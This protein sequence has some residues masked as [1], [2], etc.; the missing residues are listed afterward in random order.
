M[1][2]V[3][4]TITKNLG[5]G[6]GGEGEGRGCTYIKIN[7]QDYNLITICVYYNHLIKDESVKKYVFENYTE[8]G[9]YN[10]RNDVI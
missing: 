9:E 1:R 8:H 3:W 4:N 7:K 2:M 5:G 6:G 10:V